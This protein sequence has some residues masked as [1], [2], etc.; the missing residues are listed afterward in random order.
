M[1]PLKIGLIAGSLNGEH[2]RGMGKYLL[3]MS[4]CTQPADALSWVFFGDNASQPMRLPPKIDAKADVFEVKGHRFHLWEQLGMPLRQKRHRVDLLHYAENTLALWQPVPSVVTVHDTIPWETGEPSFYWDKLLPAALHRCAHVITISES[5]RNDILKHWPR[6]ESKLT[7]IPHGID[8]AFFGDEE[9]S[10]PALLQEL[11]GKP[12]L[13]YLGGP[14]ARKRFD[15]ALEV[16]GRTPLPD[17]Q[18][19][20]IGFGG[21]ARA[22]AARQVP[23]PL[24]SRVHFAPFVDDAA[25]RALYRQAQA[26]L[27]PTLYE[28]FGFPAVEAQASGVP[29]L[30]SALG[31]LKELIGPLAVV[32]PAHDVEAWVAAVLEACARPEHARADLAQRAQSWA[33][34]FAWSVSY[35]KHLSVYRQVIAERQ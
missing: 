15:W 33:G 11:Q 32:L 1:T 26:V 20:A 5:S 7:V 25:L 14:M 21:K 22:E 8:A 34:R 28:G 29:V 2:V 27:Y 35:E 17:L 30:M 13:L 9:P 16:L 31:S 24:R 10:P 23:D 18:L 12:Y 4:A 6:L 19:I 3:E